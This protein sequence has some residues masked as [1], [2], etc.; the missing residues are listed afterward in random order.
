MSVPSKPTAIGRCDAPGVVDPLTVAEGAIPL[1]L[2]LPPTSRCAT[3]LASSIR[4]VI[5]SP[6]TCSASSI[7]DRSVLSTSAR[8]PP[9]Y[10]ALVDVGEELERPFGVE[11]DGTE[12]DDDGTG[13]GRRRQDADERRG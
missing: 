2:P 11:R 12:A 10:N 13:T 8:S 4:P 1:K 3:C 9:A 6:T 5:R 7:S